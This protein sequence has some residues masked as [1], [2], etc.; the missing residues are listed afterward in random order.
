M[1]GRLRKKIL[2][3]IANFTADTT[4]YNVLP[5]LF[6]IPFVAVEI[7]QRCICSS[8]KQWKLQVIAEVEHFPASLLIL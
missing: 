1:Q 7:I 4:V 5:V 6:L 8:S 2:Y 3:A